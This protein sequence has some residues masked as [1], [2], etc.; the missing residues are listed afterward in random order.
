MRFDRASYTRDVLD[1]SLDHTAAAP[2]ATGAA[3]SRLAELGRGMDRSLALLAG[4]ALASQLI[5]AMLL[6][7]LPLYAQE[8]G[9]T[10]IVLGL[11]VSISAVASAIGQLVGGAVSDRTGPRRLLPAGLVAYG[12]ASLLT[13]IAATVAPV[14]GWRLLS[15][16]GSGAYIVGERLYI[17]QIV[18]RARLAFAN[19]LLQAAGSVGI[20]V[21]PVLGGVVADV[22][23][24]R[25]T[26][27]VVGVGSLL[28]AA[29]AVLLPSRYRQDSA[30]STAANPGGPIDR[31]GLSIL[32]LAN[33]A[34]V[35]GYGSFITTFA[36]F[37]MDE[38]LWTTAEIGIA[39]ALFGLGNIVVGP[40]VGGAADR[41][42][43]RWVGALATIPIVGFAFAL[44]LQ[45][46]SVLLF[47]LAL[48]AG[49]GVAGFT[50]AWFAIL[51]IATGGPHAG[52]A[53]GTVTAISSL[54]IVVGALAAGQLWES[55]DIRAGMT[56]TVV[57]MA[58]AGITLL[59]YPETRDATGGGG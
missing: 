11:M 37:A 38:L 9:A 39:F 32:L 53:F 56:L 49:G 36:P 30:A 54:G 25:S 22:T 46:P 31:R 27:L 47:V 17:R 16:L 51:G 24:L 26:F 45:A 55:I 50:A 14:V 59:A 15:G 58:L 10:P 44:I 48:A 7:V 23:D 19:G 28:L 1:P 21:G 8:L 5:V 34:F 57:A 6:P 43:R 33:L 20:I 35:A 4:L 2:T 18:D 29:V 13:S 12:A 3:P 42:G 40:W 52:R 41:W